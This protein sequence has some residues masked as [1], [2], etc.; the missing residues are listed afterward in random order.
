MLELADVIALCALLVGRG[1][2][3]SCEPL[4][5]AGAQAVGW[6]AGESYSRAKALARGGDARAGEALRALDDPTPT[7]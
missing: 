2:Q 5:R 3:V 4:W 6:G 7:A 1:E